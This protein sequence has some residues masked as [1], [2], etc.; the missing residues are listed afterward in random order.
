MEEAAWLG[1]LALKSSAPEWPVQ[2]HGSQDSPGRT[3]V[4]TSQSPHLPTLLH[5]DPG[6]HSETL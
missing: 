6:V 5:C 2:P 4:D 3:A 1:H